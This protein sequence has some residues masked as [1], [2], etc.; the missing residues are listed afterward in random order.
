MMSSDA[1]FWYAGVHAN[2]AFI[3]KINKS[4]GDLPRDFLPPPVLVCY[5]TA[6]ATTEPSE[7]PN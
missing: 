1:F 3:H 2:R 5:R 7:I 6:E 4:S